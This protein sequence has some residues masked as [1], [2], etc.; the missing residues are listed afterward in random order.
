MVSYTI[1]FIVIVHHDFF[2]SGVRSHWLLPGHLAF[3][4]KSV[5]RR[6]SLRERHCKNYVV[7]ELPANV[8]Q[9]VEDKLDFE[10]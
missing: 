4:T 5:P 8:D 6:K 1:H 2:L 9:R 3:S 7:N 10:H